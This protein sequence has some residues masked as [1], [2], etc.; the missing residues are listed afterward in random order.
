M[1]VINY[2]AVLVAGVAN[3]ALGMLWY[4]PLLFG[5]LWMKYSGISMESMEKHKKGMGVRYAVA[6][7]AGLLMAYILAHF[8]ILLPI[9]NVQVGLETAFWIWLGFMA[10]IYLDP[11]LWENKS[12]KL[13]FINIAYRLAS[14]MVMT[15]IFVVWKI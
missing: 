6:F 13:Y 15:A 3:M 5:K 7:L 1:I 9:E 8:M 2:W 4:S 10:T 11:V 14:L 12:V